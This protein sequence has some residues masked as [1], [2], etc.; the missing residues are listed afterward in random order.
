[1][2]GVRPDEQNEKEW[3]ARGRTNG[4]KMNGRREAGRTERKG[5]N[6]VRPDE[7]NEKE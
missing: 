7:R 2:D 6:G 5:M 1:M 4:T 3:T